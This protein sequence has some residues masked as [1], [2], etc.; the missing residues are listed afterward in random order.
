M[1]MSVVER[2]K[3]EAVL[4][5]PG[6]TY[7]DYFLLETKTFKDSLTPGQYRVEA[8][9]YEWRE[10]EFNEAQKA[11]LRQFR[12]SFLRGESVASAT[13]DLTK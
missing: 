2:M 12:H 10:D 8:A 11:E 3:K 7:R 5:K 1:Q 4:L 13:I 9:F 6:E